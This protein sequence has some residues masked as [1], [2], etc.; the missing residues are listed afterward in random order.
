MQA[1]ENAI[2]IILETLKTRCNG[3]AVIKES[4][5][6]NKRIESCTVAFSQNKTAKNK[7]PN[8]IMSTI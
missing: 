5:N 1:Q 4:V 8:K 6:Y 2:P 7:E 3:K